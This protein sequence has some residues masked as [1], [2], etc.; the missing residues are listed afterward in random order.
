MI[1]ND[2]TIRMAGEH[3]LAERHTVKESLVEGTAARGTRWGPDN[4]DEGVIYT[5][6]DESTMARKQRNTMLDLRSRDGSE[7]GPQEVES[8]RRRAMALGGQVPN[9]TQVVAPGPGENGQTLEPVVVKTG[10]VV[11]DP[12]ERMQYDLNMMIIRAFIKETT[13][14]EIKLVSIA[15]VTSSN[16][17]TDT[18]EVSP[19]PGQGAPAEAEE[20]PE[21]GGWGLR[22]QYHE[23]HR[24]HEETT[25]SAEGVVR[26]ADGREIRIDVELGMSRRFASDLNV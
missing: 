6:S 25:F 15:D 7:L 18:P 11:Y 26:T 8:I 21:Q 3:T 5:R 23:S 12:E 24:E 16:K 19:P 22:Y 10:E 1:I 14:R 17:A 9:D 13:G 2:S 4:L 20:A